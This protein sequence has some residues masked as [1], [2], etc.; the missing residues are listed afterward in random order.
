MILMKNSVAGKRKR[1]SLFW[2]TY[3]LVVLGVA[4]IGMALGLMFGYAIDLP[5][6][7]ELQKVRP[8]VVSY[9]YADDGRVF[10]SICDR[11]TDPGDLRSDT[12]P[13]EKRDSRG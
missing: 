1:Y 10:G 13:A 11:K 4:V 3:A 5:R 8:N 6:V 2:V 9:V 12:A 7:D